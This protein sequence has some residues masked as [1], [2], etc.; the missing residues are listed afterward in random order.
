V[1][2]LM[3]RYS[4]GGE[5]LKELERLTQLPSRRCSQPAVQ[6]TKPQRR[7]RAGEVEQLL[8]RYDQ[9]ATTQELAGEF[10][11]HRSTA[12]DIVKRHGVPVRRRGL[13]SIDVPEARRLYST[14]GWSIARLASKFGVAQDTVRQ[15]LIG[16]GT[17]LRARRGWEYQDCAND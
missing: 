7:L 4:R 9:G 12:L 8:A 14:E 16:A 11:V 17:K 1:V 2:E 5:R 3:G 15:A 10:G 6:R 13:A